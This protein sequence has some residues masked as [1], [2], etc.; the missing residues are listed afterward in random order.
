MTSCTKGVFLTLLEVP[1]LRGCCICVCGNHSSPH[2]LVGKM[3]QAGYFQPTMQK[4]ATQVIQRCDKCQRFGNVQ[5]VQVEHM[6][7]I[8]SPWLFSTWGIDIVAPLPPGKKKVNFLFVAIDYFMK[9]VEA[10][11]LV[12]ITEAKI[13]HFF[14][15]N[16][17]C[18]F[19]ILRVII[20]DN[21]RQF[22]SSKF[23]D[24]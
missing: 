5:H 19:G 1:R 22:D 9:W 4:D 17:V 6:T 24:F 21:G 11:P 23:R 15:K 7:N 8:S 3:I 20:S 18:R 2:S 12:V 10:E 13:Q 16:D 14:Q